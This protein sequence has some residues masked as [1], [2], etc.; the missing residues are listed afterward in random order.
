VLRRCRVCELFADAA[1]RQHWITYRATYIDRTAD[2][3]RHKQA[4]W[5]DVEQTTALSERAR[6]LQNAAN[7]SWL[8][9]GATPLTGS[10]P[11]GSYEA[12]PPPPT[13]AAPPAA[14]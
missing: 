5:R 11:L 6:F 9:F 2:K 8:Y 3:P 10:K 7:G 13:A 1:R 14:Q 4:R 12:G